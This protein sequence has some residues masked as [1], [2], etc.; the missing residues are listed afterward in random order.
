MEARGARD[1]PGKFDLPTA[2][3]QLFEQNVPVVALDL[4][5]AVF[6]RTAGTAL[7]LEL[8]SKLF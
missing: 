1:S 4:Y 6:Y 3:T 5:H 7:C 2:V 8:S